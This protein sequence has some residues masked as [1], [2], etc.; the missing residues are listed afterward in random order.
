MVCSFFIALFLAVICAIP[1][2]HKGAA[3]IVF[4]VSD[5]Y[6]PANM[7][8]IKYMQV[9]QSIALFVVPSVIIAYLLASKPSQYLHMDKKPGRISVII[10]ILI[11]FTAI[12]FINY[13]EFMNSKMQ[14]PVALSGVEHWMKESE[15]NAAFLSEQFLNVKNI[16]GLAFNLFMMALLP[17]LGEEL[18]FRGIF[19]R[20]FTELGKNIHFGIILS[21]ALF[22]AMHMQFYGFIPRMLLGVI[23]GYL[24]VWSGSLWIPIIAHFINNGVGVVYYYL[25]YKGSVSNT[26]ETTG[27]ENNGIPL[28]FFSFLFVI[29]LMYGF[30]KINT[31]KLPI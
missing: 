10:V 13:L 3:E 12:P 24:L 6:N 18:V 25:N 28:V 11:I 16:S 8:L 27:T 15:K 31:K 5:I 14:L 1:F 30:F 26:L 17:A 7:G 4:S 20:L 19:Q 21:A 29:L 22:S 9:V 2:L 23:F